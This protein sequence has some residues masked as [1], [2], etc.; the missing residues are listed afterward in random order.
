MT[1]IPLINLDPERIGVRL[2]PAFE[3]LYK[4]HITCNTVKLMGSPY[5]LVA[6]ITNE[7]AG[8]QTKLPT[9]QSDPTKI[10]HR[11]EGLQRIV[12]NEKNEFIVDAS[13]AGNNI[14]LVGI[15]GPKGQCDEV[16][17]KHMGRNVYDVTYRV[18]DPG[19]YVIAAKWGEDHIPGSPFTLGTL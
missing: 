12:L 17:I 2:N 14:L 11:G 1:K 8:N 19:Q 7:E 10:T 6:Q 4:V 5:F 18:Q 3:G 16:S 13:S 9:F 15:C